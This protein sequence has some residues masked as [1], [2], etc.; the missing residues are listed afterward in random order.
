MMICWNQSLLPAL[1]LCWGK[2]S[3]EGNHCSLAAAALNPGM[4]KH[5]KVVDVN[6]LYFS[7]AHAHASVLQATV[8]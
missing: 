3:L 4:L 6:H 1:V 7:L 8:R 5:G 2:L